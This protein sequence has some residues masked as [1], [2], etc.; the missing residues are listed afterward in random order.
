MLGPNTAVMLGIP[1]FER[2]V[3]FLKPAPPGTKM[4][5]WRGSSAPADSLRVIV[6]NRLASA[7]SSMRALL[8]TELGLAEPPR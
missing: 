6:G 4:S 3:M 1:S 5:A 7:I 8:A 2:C